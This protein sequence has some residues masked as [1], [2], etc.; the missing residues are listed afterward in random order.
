MSPDV[1]CDCVCFG[2]LGK[3]RAEMYMCLRREN[4]VTVDA[5]GKDEAVFIQGTQGLVRRRIP[6]KKKY[7]V[8][9]QVLLCSLV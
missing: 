1:L 7:T 4:K 9:N 6:Q 8:P 5:T 2:N 3:W